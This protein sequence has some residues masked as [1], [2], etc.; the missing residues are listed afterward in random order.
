[1]RFNEAIS[2]LFNQSYEIRLFCI[3]QNI[4]MMYW[5]SLNNLIHLWF[6]CSSKRNE[7]DIRFW[8]SYFIEIL[9]WY[10]PL[11]CAR[12]VDHIFSLKIL[13]L[14]ESIILYWR[15]YHTRIFYDIQW[16]NFFFIQSII[17]DW[18]FFC[19]AERLNDIMEISE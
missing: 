5:R 1:M 12:F 8:Q 18:P 17:W 3:M 16:G 10:W 4:W 15:A 19:Y 9:I 2:F 6:S 11:S 13:S 7:N 14:N